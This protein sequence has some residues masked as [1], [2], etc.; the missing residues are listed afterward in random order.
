MISSGRTA[1]KTRVLRCDQGLLTSCG[2]DHRHSKWLLH[3]PD[4]KVASGHPCLDP[5]HDGM[6]TSSYRKMPVNA[7][8]T[9]LITVLCVVFQ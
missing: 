1:G 4:N 3:F 6:P 7:V 9:P 8:V 2:Y 5:T